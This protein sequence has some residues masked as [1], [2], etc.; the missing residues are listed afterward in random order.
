MSG[1]PFGRVLIMMKKLH[2]ASFDI[3]KIKILIVAKMRY[4]HKK[5][6]LDLIMHQTFS[7]I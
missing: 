4:K 7:L 6:L 1:L 3:R 5:K 2:S